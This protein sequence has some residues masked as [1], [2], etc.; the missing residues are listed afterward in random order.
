MGWCLFTLVLKKKKKSMLIR[1]STSLKQLFLSHICG[2]WLQ[3]DE[4]TNNDFYSAGPLHAANCIDLKYFL[5]GNRFSERQC[6]I[7][8]YGESY[9]ITLVVPTNTGG[10]SILPV[11]L[12]A[13][14]KKPSPSWRGC[15]KSLLISLSLCPGAGTYRNMAFLSAGSD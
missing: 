1:K 8:W 4:C 13:I 9:L 3:M 2:Q 11:R 5:Q 15:F 7:S 12:V 6:V 14:T 10:L